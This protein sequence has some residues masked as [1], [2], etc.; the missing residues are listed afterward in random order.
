MK[1]IP[2]RMCIVTREKLPKIE[3]IRVVKFND[4]INIDLTGKQNGKG[5]YLKKDVS[6]IEQAKKRKTLSNV[7][8]CEINEDIYTELL[9]LI[10]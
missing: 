7:F 10:K 4:E 5:C 9:N 6:V 1:K 3:L 2:Y 8:G